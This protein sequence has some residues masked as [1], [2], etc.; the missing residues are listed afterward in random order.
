[1]APPNKNLEVDTAHIQ[2]YECK[3]M[4]IIII[5]GKRTHSG[6]IKNLNQIEWLPERAFYTCAAFAERIIGVTG[7]GRLTVLLDVPLSMPSLR[8]PIY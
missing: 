3:V 1:M 8:D 6:L 4:G 7:I 5:K 2:V